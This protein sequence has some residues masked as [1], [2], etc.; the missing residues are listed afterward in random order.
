MNEHPGIIRSFAMAG[1]AA[2]AT[3]WLI[4]LPLAAGRPMSADPAALTAWWSAAGTPAAVMT[5]ARSVGV[6]VGVYLTLVAT[7]GVI[8]ALAA[9]T[10][11]L[12]V[13]SSIW[14]VVSTDAIRRMVTVGTI[15]LW[16]TTPIVASA[17]SDPAPS[18]V[19][20]DLGPVTD[21]PAP[22]VH[23]LETWIVGPGDN[24]WQIARRT[25]AAGGTEAPIDETTTY[26][27]RLITEN[28]ATLGSN[29]DLIYP[30]QVL[31]LPAR[32]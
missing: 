13:V 28:T 22:S 2:V 26:W 30:G 14:H 5:L 10:G 27:R 24:L 8:A 3:Q 23:P 9:L 6:V 29:P 20:V 16:T 12:G 17:S 11:R 7:L 15:A 4:Q 25:L 19:L 18:I 31:V 21:A 32:E 1:L